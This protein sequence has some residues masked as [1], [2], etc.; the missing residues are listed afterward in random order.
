VGEG[1]KRFSG[2]GE[3][4]GDPEDERKRQQERLLRPLFIPVLP[5]LLGQCCPMRCPPDETAGEASQT[6]T[7]CHN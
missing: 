2:K 4:E 1:E 7:Y 6:L 5:K 3:L